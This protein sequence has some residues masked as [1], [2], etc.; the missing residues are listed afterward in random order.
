MFPLIF[1]QFNFP[2]F[3]DLNQSD[4]QAVLTINWLNIAYL[5][6]IMAN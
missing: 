4:Q 3:L 5:I 2:Y 6:D 1:I